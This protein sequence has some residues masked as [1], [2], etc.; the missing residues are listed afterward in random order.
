MWDDQIKEFG[1]RKEDEWKSGLKCNHC[2]LF[3]SPD[4]FHKLFRKCHLCVFP[5]IG[6][7]A[8]LECLECEFSVEC[9]KLTY[10][11]TNTCVQ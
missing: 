3:F 10:Q 6:N 8:K 1:G 4:K 9:K 2:E 5:K 11:H 7:S